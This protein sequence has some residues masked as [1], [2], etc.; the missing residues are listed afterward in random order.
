MAAIKPQAVLFSAAERGFAQAVSRLAYCNPFLPERILCERDA[1]GPDFVARD[2]VWNVRVDRDVLHP[3]LVRLSERVAALA[4]ALRERLER[5][6]VARP[7]ERALYDDLVLYHLYSRYEDRLY[8]VIAPADGP[9]VTRTRVACYG[10]FQRD[11]AQYWNERRAPAPHGTAHLFACLFQIRRAFHHIFRVLIGGSPPAAEL[12]AAVWQS[13]F[14][15]DMRRY[16]RAL[17]DQMDDVTTLIVGPSGTGKEL[18]ARAIALSRYLPFDERTQGFAHDF[19]ASFHALNLS[20]LS[21]TLVESE[22]FGHRRGAFTGALDDRVGWFEACPP[23]GTVFL[24]EIGDVDPAIQVK[25]LRVLQTRTFQ[26]LGDTKPLR[27]HGKVIAATNR[28]L[29]R[30]MREERFREDFYYRLCS[31]VI[32]TP[33][34]EEQLHD[35]PGELRNLVRFI[36]GRVAGETE[37]EALADQATA[38]IEAHLGRSYRW[39]GNVRELEQCVR[40]VLIRAEYR[41]QLSAPAGGRDALAAAVCAGTL[42]ADELLSRYCSLV[43]AQTGSYQET[44]RRL[45]LDRRTVKSKVDPALVDELRKEP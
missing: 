4:G 10:E 13:V 12:R 1:L 18:A 38:W 35:D 11:A 21:P 6:A 43:F 8:D 22:L 29:A 26:R 3:N 37:A 24:D 7:D 14:T 17:Y 41:P 2:R 20:A 28:D 31:D 15:H 40:N 33:A 30:E 25:L 19:A 16:R 45:G 23:R 42:S 39:P 5:G 44:A 34:L 36:A 27:F 9:P 32:R